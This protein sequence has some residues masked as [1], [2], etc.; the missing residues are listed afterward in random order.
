MKMNLFGLY[1]QRHAG[2]T[3]VTSARDRYRSERSDRGDAT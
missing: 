1:I 3:T 2:S